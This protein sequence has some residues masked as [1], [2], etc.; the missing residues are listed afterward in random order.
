MAGLAW[1]S[2]VARIPQVRDSLGLDAGELGLVLL[3][4]ALGSFAAMPFAG[5]VVMR[6]GSARTVQLAAVVAAA[7]ICTAG[8][9][10]RES[11]PATVLGLLLFGAGGGTWDIAMNVEAAAVERR[12]AR[13]IMARF[14]AS[15]SVGTVVGAGTGAA[16]IA[17]GI[18]VTT[19]LGVLAI[20]A[21]GSAIVAARSFLPAVREVDPVARG[22]SSRRRR[23]I[24]LESWREPRTLLI[25]GF[26]FCAAFTEGSGS[27]WIA[28]TLID[29][30]GAGAVLGAFA[31]GCFVAT[32]TVSRLIAPWVLARWN[33]SS[34]LRA[35]GTLAIAG[36]SMLAWGGSQGV[37]IAGCV[38]W[39]LGISLAFPVAMSAASDDPARAAARV[40][41]VSSIGYTAFIA[42]PPFIGLL[43]DHVGIRDA[44]AA[45]VV[46]LAIGVML[47]GSTRQLPVKDDDSAGQIVA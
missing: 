24:A 14:H 28:V 8:F 5:V 2:W 36:V 6:L 11:V 10:Q 32:M 30:H 7:G 34:V 16:C 37:A 41:V 35:Y 12:A 3:A 19:N 29:G 23:A 38:V 18:G 4:G 44:L 31:F 9:G 22:E 25:G 17:L 15:F 33:R 13:A 1:T 47:A 46:V 39:G 40:S 43:A 20:V 42:G 45:I 27:D 21:A 26:V